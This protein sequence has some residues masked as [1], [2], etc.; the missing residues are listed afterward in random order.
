MTDQNIQEWLEIGTATT[1]DAL[2][3]L[4]LKGQCHG[5]TLQAGRSCAVPACT[6]RYLPV[7]TTHGTVGD[8]IDDVSMGGVEVLGLKGRTI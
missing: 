5:I 3:R 2:D 4:G 8:F 7:D 1:S 6:V